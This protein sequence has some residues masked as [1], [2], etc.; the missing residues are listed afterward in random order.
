MKATIFLI[1]ENY[2]SAW[3]KNKLIDQPTLSYRPDR[4][5]KQTI[6]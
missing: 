6:Y 2:L 5:R 3:N 4:V 1:H